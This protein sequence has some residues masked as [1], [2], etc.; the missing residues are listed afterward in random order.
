MCWFLRA[1]FIQR[2]PTFCGRKPCLCNNIFIYQD[3]RRKREKSTHDKGR[4]IAF[5]FAQT[6]GYCMQI[7]HTLWT[8]HLRLAHAMSTNVFVCLGQRRKIFVYATQSLRRKSNYTYLFRLDLCRLPCV[9]FYRSP[10]SSH[11]S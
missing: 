11:L 7:R 5:F 9:K 6:G 1:S 2:A 4:N 3:E 8:C 10:F